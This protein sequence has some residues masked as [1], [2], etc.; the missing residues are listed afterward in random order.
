LLIAKVLHA[1]GAEVQLHGH[2]RSKLKLADA[3]GIQT[4]F[5]AEI[6]ETS[7]L[8]WVV[9]ATGSRA[10]LEQAIKMVRPRGTIIMKSTLHDMPVVDTA[11]IIVDEITLLGSRCGPF[12]PAL[13]LLATGNV[14]VDDMISERVPLREA[15]R[16]FELAASEGVLK[17]LLIPD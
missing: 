4:V 11:K 6:Q 17:V 10:G 12:E 8:A 5:S 2:H 16:A 7:D 15:R 9:E 14:R 13:Q 1:Y 3:A